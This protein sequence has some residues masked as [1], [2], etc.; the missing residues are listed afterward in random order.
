MIRFNSPNHSRYQGEGYVLPTVSD[1]LEI[2]K[3]GHHHHH[4]S[5]SH[6]HEDYHHHHYPHGGYES[7]GGYGNYGPG[8]GS[9][10][11]GYGPYGSQTFYGNNGNYGGGFGTS[12]T[13]QDDLD[14]WEQYWGASSTVSWNI[15]NN[16]LKYHMSNGETISTT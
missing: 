11:N 10:V 8:Y 9:F 13:L 16:R 3:Q 14:C 2:M 5:S 12:L 7:H 15:I 6:S 4:H 1:H